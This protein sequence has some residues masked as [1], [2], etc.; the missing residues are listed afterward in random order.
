MRAIINLTGDILCS[1]GVTDRFTDNGHIDYSPIL[2]QIKCS[3]SD[4]DLLVGNLE[5]PIAGAELQFTHERYCFNTPEEF[6]EM[7]RDT[8][9][10]LVTLANNHCMDRG[11]EGLF[12]TLDN[13]DRIGLP[14]TGLNRDGEKRYI[15]KEVNGIK[16]AFVNYTYG[17]NA[18]AHHIFLEN[19]TSG[20]VNLFQPQET[21]PGS[22][23]LLESMEHI[24]RET[25][26]LYFTQ[27]EE[28][29]RY[30]K[31]HLDMLRADISDAK[32]E[33]DFVIFIMHSGGQY[34]PTPDPYTEMLVSKLREYGADC[35]V[36]HHPHV[37]HGYDVKDG[38]FCAYSL[39]N[40]V[41]DPVDAQDPVGAAH[42]ALLKLTVEKDETGA[43]LTD[44]SFSLIRTVRPEDGRIYCVDCFDKPDD[45]KKISLYEASLLTGKPETELKREYIL[46]I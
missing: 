46:D 20:R 3:L 35:I 39:G 8:G 44:A 29:D 7:L 32:K 43:K 37:I 15:V 25:E 34:N 21:L 22:I 9:F 4:C 40:L 16:L 45:E 14:H 24:G 41:C 2:E 42:S 19:D 33:S 31:P 6:A 18:F 27:N 11:E 12:R 28:Y 30:I 13:L 17:T 1:P 23:H 38:V 5:T 10:G 36:G 26:R